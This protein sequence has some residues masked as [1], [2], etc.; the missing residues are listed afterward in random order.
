[1]KSSK[2]IRIATRSS[3]L[4]LWQ[5]NAVKQKLES[6]GHNCVLVLIESTGDVQLNQPI[7]ALGITGVFTKQLDIAL[8]NN[9][10]DIAVHSLKDVPTKLPENI[11]LSAVLERGANEDV[12]LVKDK[13]ILNSTKATIATSSVRR[14]AQWL[15][16]YPNHKMVPIRGNVQ[17][18][19]RKFDET[20]DIDAVIFAKAGLERLNLLTT[21]TITLDWMLPAPSQGIIGIVCR[22]DDADMKEICSAINHQE[23]FIA[24][25]VERQF[26]NRLLGGCSVPISALAKISDNQLVFHGS[27]HALDGSKYFEEK[28]TLLLTEWE[29]SG[30]EAA[31][32]ILKQAGA[33][34]LLEEIKNNNW[35][36][37]SALD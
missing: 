6:I 1:M 33:K 30:K 13:E 34:E 3:P 2:K 25:Y 23:S 19:L 12:I 8:L 15:A 37:E 5:A 4:A 36:N 9:Q 21:N 28:R 18:R 10:A 35:D 20:N 16:K 26:L 29:S 24:G 11:F 22:D 17:T 14:S 31:E 7:Y 32:K 27:I